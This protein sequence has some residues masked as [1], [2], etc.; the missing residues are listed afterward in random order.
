MEIILK[1]AG[2]DA[3]AVGMANLEHL[4][5]LDGAPPADGGNELGGHE[6]LAAE[7]I[8]HGV[9]RCNL[10]LLIRGI[11]ELEGSHP[12]PSSGRFSAG[13]FPRRA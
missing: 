12:T 13:F 5:L 8:A 10:M 3:Q 7:K 9:H 6:L 1:L 4:A 11:L 2:R